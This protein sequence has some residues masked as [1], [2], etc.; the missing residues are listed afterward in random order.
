MHLKS[1]TISS[2]GNVLRE[3]EFRIGLNLI[4][5]NTPIENIKETG[6]N[7]GKTTVL[8]LI[9]F[10][11]GSTGKNVYTDPENPKEVYA[12]VKDFL[13][14]K[15]VLITLILKENLNLEKSQEI[16]IEKNFLSR[17]HKILSIDG[18]RKTSEEFD[19]T[20][21]ELLF[22]GQYGK[23]PTYRQ[24]ISHNIRYKDLSISNTLKTLDRY[25]SA[26][27][28]EALHL[29]M[30][31]CSFDD[32]DIKGELQTKI[33]VETN[34]KKR[35]E[36]SQTKSAYESTLAIIKRDIDRLN[37]R[38]K[39]WNINPEFEFL[40]NQMTSVKHSLRVTSEKISQLTL[41]KGLI[42]DAEKEMLD[43]ISQID[44]DQLRTIYA[45]AKV[46]MEE[47][48]KTFDELLEFH[49]KMLERKV[50]YIIKDVPRID[51][52][53]SKYKYELSRLRSLEANVAAKLNKSETLEDLERVTNELNELHQRKGELE[54][55]VQQINEVEDNVENLNTRLKNI[56]KDLFSEVFE[57]KVALKKDKFNE[58]F[59]S[60]SEKLYNEKYALKYD[61]LE[62][63]KKQKYYEFSSF[64]TNF[65][66]GKK[67]GEISCFD[68]AYI[69]FAD[70]E[71]IPCM[72]FL[73]NDKKELMH[74][75]QLA[76]ISQMVEKEN[77]QFVAAILRDK[78]PSELNKAEFFVV[79]LSQ[80]D[81]LFR[82][83]KN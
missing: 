15:Q 38:K 73:L 77:I 34:Y 51:D 11:L 71:N 36:K 28:Y 55:I 3:I 19:E 20:L 61:I 58:Y 9:D 43:N 53:I 41:R 60:V 4:V 72:H 17:K 66:S 78:L 26:V 24:I 76:A 67:Q 13:V 25:T 30:L 42:L 35:L 68:I 74:G 12:L 37:E 32:G 81:K 69:L 56:E 33:A 80:K 50:G 70:E 39:G 82:I 22:P 49:N 6:N 46:Q 40:L 63:K 5:D 52:Q 79:E 75:N 65:S 27:E 64:N 1:L 2:K 8:K 83:E 23:K 47:I 45:Q 29:F 57:Q 18:V 54:T 44:T 16:C 10:C 62:N 14:E 59:S 7:V 21:T 48:H 31:G